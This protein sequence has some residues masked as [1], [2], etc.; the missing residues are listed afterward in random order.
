M[1][2]QFNNR[3]EL[4]DKNL[5]VRALLGEVLDFSEFYSGLC[6]ISLYRDNAFFH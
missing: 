4:W 2:K 3:V 5:G 1:Y 6:S